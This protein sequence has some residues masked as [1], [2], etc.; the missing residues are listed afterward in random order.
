MIYLP[1]IRSGKSYLVAVTRVA[2]RRLCGNH[3]LGEFSFQRFIHAG[4]DVSSPCNP[5]GLINITPARKRVS[6]CAAETC[7]RTSERFD[8]G[9][10]VVC[11]VLELEK[12]FLGLAV[13]IDIDIYA[14]CVVF[15][16]DL[17]IV[18][19]PLLTQVPRPYGGHVHQTDVLFLPAEFLAHAEIF[20]IGF[21]HL[22]RNERIVYPDMLDHRS[23]SRM[24]AMVAPVSI[25]YAE[26]GLI[27]IPAFIVEI[28]DNFLQIR[29][30]H[31]QAH[32]FAIFA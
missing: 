15:L 30:I 12:P 13:N 5:H 3:F 8:F 19:K 32:L 1:D 17:K 11:F 2:G 27:G 10:M 18:K 31:R 25:Q 9:R 24:A 26:F 21:P 6:D 16:A 4:I 7:G 29:R 20:V 22:V 28:F 23:E 14:A